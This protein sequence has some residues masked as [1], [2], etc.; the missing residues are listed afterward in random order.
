MDDSI[1]FLNMDTWKGSGKR[2]FGLTFTQI[3]LMHINRC[4]MNGS[5]EWHGG[6]WNTKT[7]NQG[8]VISTEKVYVR[9]SREVYTNSIIML[10]AI[11]TGYFDKKMEE[12]D[13]KLY[14]KIK[15]LN[16]KI[17]KATDKK[18]IDK[19]IT[20]KIGYAI[21]LFEELVKLCKRHNFFEEEVIEEELE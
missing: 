17:K 10:R 11:L 7:I 9:D 21:E 13:K 3:I 5:T 18:E 15:E 8:G 20:D 16:E 2:Q 4:V 6:Y 19:Y 12:R 14:P 1:Q